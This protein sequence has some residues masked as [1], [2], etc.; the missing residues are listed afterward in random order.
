MSVHKLILFFFSGSFSHIVVVAYEMHVSIYMEIWPGITVGW[1][2]VGCIQWH[3]SIVVFK[4]ISI[5]AIA[6]MSDT[7][8][9]SG[10]KC[11]RI[12]IMN[13]YILLWRN[14]LVQT[15]PEQ[16]SFN[17]P[18]GHKATSM[19]HLFNSVF[20]LFKFRIFFQFCQILWLYSTDINYKKNMNW[21]VEN[22]MVIEIFLS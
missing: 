18:V 16:H 12:K 21:F 2:F 13:I 22:Y 3:C 14:Y 1:C 15:Y 11:L 17:F 7:S 4:G 8:K 9:Q 6:R 5:N 19:L 20:F 10:Y